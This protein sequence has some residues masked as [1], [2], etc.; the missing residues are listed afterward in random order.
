[1]TPYIGQRVVAWRDTDDATVHS[2]GPG[3]YAARGTY[4]PYD[5]VTYGQIPESEREP[6]AGAVTS[7]DP[8]ALMAFT[9]AAWDQAVADGTET[10]EVADKKIEQARARLAA[11]VARPMEDRVVRLWREIHSAAKL[12]LDSGEVVWGHLCVW[13]PEDE[14]ADAVAGRAVVAV[15]VHEPVSVTSGEAV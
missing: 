5:R 11:D 8:D 13:G 10:R 6:L 3:I 12:L 4:P 7:H 1:M 15:P 2:Y 9:V 14:M